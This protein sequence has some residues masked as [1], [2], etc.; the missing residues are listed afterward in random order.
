MA[1]PRA[2]S[3]PAAASGGLGPRPSNA[4]GPRAARPHRQ[5]Q[6][7]LTIMLTQAQYATAVRAGWRTLRLAACFPA[8]LADDQA[9]LKFERAAADFLRSLEDSG[10]RARVAGTFV[11]PL[12]ASYRLVSIRFGMSEEMFDEVQRRLTP[13]GWVDLGAVGRDWPGFAAVSTDASEGEREV[14]LTG[15]PTGFGRTELVSHLR[16]AQWPI[17]R[18]YRPTHPV[19]GV[20]RDDAIAIVVP[21]DFDLPKTV[22]LEVQEGQVIPLQVRPQS[23]L[24]PAPHFPG[25]PAEPHVPDL[26]GP[27][28]G[29]QHVVGLQVQVQHPA[30]RSR[31]GTNPQRDQERNA[32]HHLPTCVVE[33]MR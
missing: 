7:A 31:D 8:A 10:G 27:L 2:R 24:P 5:R 25:A 23:K 33:A 22:M 29:Q 12:G 1:S 9:K 28:P 26:G 18:S 6:Q 21:A 13:Q 32:S 4:A 20:K 15:L 16:E 3:P 14:L 17:S 19:L 30:A 11:S